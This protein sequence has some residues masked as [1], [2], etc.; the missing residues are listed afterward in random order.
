[1]KDL[2]VYIHIP[3]CFAKCPYCAFFSCTNYQDRYD[4]YFNTLAK[5]I[6][7]KAKMYRD[8]QVHTIYIGGGTPNLVPHKYI[9]ECIENIKRNFHLSKNVEITIEQYPEYITE[10]NIRAYKK[11]GINRISLGLQTTSDEDLK[12][13]TRR[14][15]YNVFLEKYT[16]VKQAGFKDIGIDLIFGYPHHTLK[17]WKETLDLISQ[18][19]IQHISCYSLEVEEGTPYCKL[20]EKDQLQLPS[21]ITDR[22][23]YHY[24]CR[25]LDEKGFKQYEISNFAEEGYECKHNLNFWNYQDYLGFGAGAYSRVNN[26]K[27]NNPEDIQ[28]YMEGDWDINKE[29]ITKDISEKEKIILGLRLNQGIMYDATVFNKKYMHKTKDHMSLNAY[30]RDVYNHVVEDI[31]TCL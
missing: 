12:L 7:T 6:S 5:E 26:V 18:L 25:F 13:L 11:I 28:R 1:M 21:E 22:E 16:L 3:F 19:D 9:V 15:T 17:Q 14:Y 31:F 8:R 2:N 27:S 20:Q 29:I 10:E 23:M 4:E 24:T 30:G